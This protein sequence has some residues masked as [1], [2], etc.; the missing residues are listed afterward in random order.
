VTTS[1][2][3][4]AIGGASID[5]ASSL[6]QLDQD[7]WTTAVKPA[8]EVLQGFSNHQISLDELTDIYHGRSIAV[9]GDDEYPVMIYNDDSLI[10]VAERCR[11]KGSG[12]C[13]QR[14]DLHKSSGIHPLPSTTAD[15]AQ[16]A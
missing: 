4:I 14:P 8:K 11:S 2:R 15:A 16:P 5:L 6:E 1:L 12:A 9:S 10:A 7:N 3:R 13:V